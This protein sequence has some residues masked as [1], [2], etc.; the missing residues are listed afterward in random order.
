LHPF[1]ILIGKM[2]AF[3]TKFK[4]Q[5]IFFSSVVSSNLHES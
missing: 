3:V 5:S 1:R 4:T 2:T